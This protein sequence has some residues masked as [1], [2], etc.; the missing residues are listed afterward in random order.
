MPASQ[1]YA[2]TGY[3]SEYTSLPAM[4]PS[5]RTAWIDRYNGTGEIQY[6]TIFAEILR[7]AG[8]C[9]SSQTKRKAGHVGCPQLVASSLKAVHTPVETPIRF[10]FTRRPRFRSPSQLHFA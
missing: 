1:T 10:H 4:G 6:L 7:S 9:G 5:V 8:G 2:V 3:G